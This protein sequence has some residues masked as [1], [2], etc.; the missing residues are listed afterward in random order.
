MSLQCCS[1]SG[2]R[3][4]I[5]WQSPRGYVPLDKYAKRSTDSLQ[6]TLMLLPAMSMSDGLISA[7]SALLS[8]VSPLNTCHVPC[9]RTS[10]EGEMSG[11]AL[12]SQPCWLSPDVYKDFWSTRLKP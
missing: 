8:S 6:R 5:L 10:R 2:V 4:F 12:E 1:N 7:I 11:V 9:C 3:N